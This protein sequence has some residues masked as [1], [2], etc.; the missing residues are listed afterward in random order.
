MWGAW[1]GV[2]A[3]YLWLVYIRKGTLVAG[4]ICKGEKKKNFISK[5]M[6]KKRKHTVYSLLTEKN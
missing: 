1:A 4:L 3:F 6:C 2:A 5:K